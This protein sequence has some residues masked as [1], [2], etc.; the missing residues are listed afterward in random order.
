MIGGRVR[1]VVLA[2]LLLPG[3]TA[4]VATGAS[5]TAAAVTPSPAPADVT[6]GTQLGS[7]QLS[8]PCTSGIGVG[9]AFDGTNL[10]YSCYDQSPD[11]FR[12]DPTT[13]QVSASY[14]IAG[15][16][17]SLAYDGANNVMYAGYGGPNPGEVY[18]IQLDG[19]ENVT[20]SSGIFN[21]CSFFCA[22]D[23]DDGLAY[24]A[25]TG[26]LYYSPDT[27]QTIWHLST[28]GQVLDS[29]PWVGT[30]CYNS[31]LAIGDELLFEGADGCRTIWVVDKATP[32]T[33][34]FTFPTGGTRDEGLACD[35]VTFGQDAIWSKDA[36]TP[37]AFAFAIPAG[38]CGVG[39]RPVSPSR[40]VEF[41]HGINGK[42]PA[43][44][45]GGP[46]NGG[47]GDVLRSLC[48]NPQ[49]SPKSFRYYQDAGY[50]Y[51]SSTN[52]CTDSSG[53][54]MPGPDVATGGLYI[55]PNSINPAF[56]DSKGALS[57]SSAALHDQLGALPG[58]TTV[59]ANSMG[60]AITRGWLTLTGGSSGD[61]SLSNADSVVFLQGAQEGSWADGAAQ[62]LGGTPVVG[63]GLKWIASKVS[64]LF[65][66][67][68]NRPGVADLAPRSNWYQ[69]VNGAPVPSP[70]V[71]PQLAYYNFYSNLNLLFQLNFFFYTQTVA[72]V[73]LGDLVMLP[74]SNN[75]TAMPV[76]GGEKFLPGNAQTSNR[77]QFAMDGSVGLSVNPADAVNPVGSALSKLTAAVYDLYHNPVS[78][79]S[80]PS[81][82]GSDMVDSCN[83]SGQV[84]AAD[85]I[86]TILQNPTSGCS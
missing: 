53:N 86:L 77:H 45:C 61:P 64:S 26:T 68:V 4:V 37:E 43:F 75:P 67:D 10:W 5:N 60:G 12:A 73:D 14:N 35:D 38:S 13:G 11:L 76:G 1:R 15:G 20:S 79:F 81:K 28:T 27:S 19:T 32:T 85:Q 46:L 40:N 25:G 62:A 44:E 39:G 2:S 18:A 56:C 3:L 65:G 6:P 71:P 22:T 84:T 36:Y 72:T 83:G 49:F 66:L 63:P 16:L 52:S 74:G 7:V 9:V 29:F 31:G 33:L 59:I 41:V 78:H 24:D 57:Y 55:N 80:F 58:P 50:T 30:S 17:G 34:D 8:Q 23:I 42:F 69:T 51:Q 21:T 48:G 47:F 82:D 54:P 70:G